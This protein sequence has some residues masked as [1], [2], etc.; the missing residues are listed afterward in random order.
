MFGLNEKLKNKRV[1]L[2][3]QSPRRKELLGFIVNDFE[4]CPA[5]GDEIIPVGTTPMFVTVVLAEQKC[6]EVVGRL[7]PD[8]DTIVIACD[9]AVICN[10]KI[11]GKPKNK[12]DAA[13][14]LRELSGNTH[15]VSSGMCIYYK[16]KYHKHLDTSSVMFS[17]LTESDIKEYVD[18]GEPMDKAGAYGIQGLG[19]LLVRK[20]VGDYYTIVGLPVNS[21]CQM[22]S[23]IL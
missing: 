11:F 14:M 2:A 21:L 3:S 19:G 6:S 16:G 7:S 4:V 23:G 18:S 20:I 10:N 15:F 12:S 22:L 5:Y 8:D 9:T 13:R 17:E 1:I